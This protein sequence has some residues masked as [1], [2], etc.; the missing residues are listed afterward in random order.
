MK[1]IIGEYRLIPQGTEI[2][3]ISNQTTFNIT[4]DEIVEIKHTCI[5]SD[6]VFIEPRQLIFNIPGYIPTIIGK[7]RDEWGVSLSKTIPYKVPEP[8]F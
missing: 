4:Q 6:Y 8:Q 3:S 2:W 7:G 5:G 1:D